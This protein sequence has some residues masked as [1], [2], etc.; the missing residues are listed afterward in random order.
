MYTSAIL[1][2]LSR[3]EDGI[4]SAYADFAAERLAFRLHFN[5]AS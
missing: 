5:S 2:A 4:N 3:R 1:V